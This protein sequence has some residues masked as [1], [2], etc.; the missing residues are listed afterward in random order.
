MSGV[1]SEANDSY[2]IVILKE[3]LQ[4]KILTAQGDKYGTNSNQCFR[5]IKKAGIELIEWWEPNQT[6]KGRHLMRQLKQT[7]DNVKAAKAL[8]S[9][10]QSKIKRAL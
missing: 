1:M 3:F 2:T 10:L 4:V 8:L 6:K 5:Y 9:I 7:P